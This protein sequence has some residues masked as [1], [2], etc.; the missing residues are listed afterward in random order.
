[1]QLVAL[2]LF[3]PPASASASVMQPHTSAPIP[4]PPQAPPPSGMAGGYI[5]SEF[6]ESDLEGGTQAGA[7]LFKGAAP[8][9]QQDSVAHDAGAKRQKVTIVAPPSSN[10]TAAPAAAPKPSGKEATDGRPSQGRSL[11]GGSRPSAA[12]TTLTTHSNL[13]AHAAS[14]GAAAAEPAAPAAGPERRRVLGVSTKRGNE[15]STSAATAVTGKKVRQCSHAGVHAL[16]KL[17]AAA[18]SGPHEQSSARTCHVVWSR[19]M[20]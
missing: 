8:K 4:R 10:T 6:A 1:M 19:A 15:N 18:P 9:A 14:K 12:V 13:S 5:D 17:A 11:F 20:P 3:H 2:G 7:G 16:H